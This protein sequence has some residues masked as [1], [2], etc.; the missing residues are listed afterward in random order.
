MNS[1]LRSSI[2]R[3]D[4]PETLSEEYILVDVFLASREETPALAAL[5]GAHGLNP[6][7]IPR[8]QKATYDLQGIGDLVGEPTL[9]IPRKSARIIFDNQ[10]EGSS[11]LR[12]FFKPE[13]FPPPPRPAPLR[14]SSISEFCQSRADPE[15]AINVSH[16]RG[17]T[18]PLLRRLAN[19]RATG[20][21]S[22]GSWRQLNAT[23][24]DN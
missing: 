24:R 15:S 3:G 17:V 10:R 22:R 2:S 12:Q 11:S 19:N 18:M 20:H 23:F 5:G 14:S 16:E 21:P 4:C 1:S 13:R 7:G 8:Q 9:G 6:I